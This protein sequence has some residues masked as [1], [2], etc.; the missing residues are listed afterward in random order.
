MTTASKHVSIYTLPLTGSSLSTMVDTIDRAISVN[1][2]PSRL[3]HTVQMLT[4]HCDPGYQSPTLSLQRL[5]VK[6]PYLIHLHSDKEFHLP[7]SN[8]VCSNRLRSLSLRKHSLSSCCSLLNHLPSVMSLS[9][10][11]ISCTTSEENERSPKPVLSITR[12]KLC[13]TSETVIT[14]PDITQYFPNVEEFYFTVQSDSSLRSDDLVPYAKINL[15]LPKLTYL[16]Y[17]EIILPAKR[18]SLVASGWLD[19]MV[20]GQAIYYKTMDISSIIFKRWLYG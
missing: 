5:F 10:S 4:I 12:L 13:L 15:F 9:L 7:P 20:S 18:D 3:Q 1:S 11:S 16:R 14:L 2:F 6:L 8:I 17:V 19:S